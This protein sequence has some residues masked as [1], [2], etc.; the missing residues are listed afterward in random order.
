MVGETQKQVEGIPK[1]IWPVTLQP[2]LTLGLLLWT[3][4]KSDLNSELHQQNLIITVLSVY[5][6]DTEITS[7]T[8]HYGFLLMLKYTHIKSGY[9][10]DSQSTGV[11]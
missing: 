6:T 10:G 8:L 2:P 7:I 3:Q 5:F 1:D 9:T 4:E 11:L